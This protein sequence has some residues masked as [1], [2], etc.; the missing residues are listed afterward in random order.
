MVTVTHRP[1]EDYLVA[2]DREAEEL[3]AL[4]AAI[5]K[6]IKMTGKGGPRSAAYFLANKLG[7]S[8][9][10]LAEM[11]EMSVR[12]VR[13]KINRFEYYVRIAYRRPL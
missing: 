5:R 13:R 11:G 4:R 12:T 1:Q 2:R 6:A 7:M 9:K 8:Q 3:A 10:E